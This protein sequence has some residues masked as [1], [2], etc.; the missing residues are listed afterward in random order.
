MKQSIKRV[1]STFLCAILALGVFGCVKSSGG[2]NAVISEPGAKGRYIEQEI[3]IP[4][5]EGSTEQISHWDWSVGERDRSIC[6]YL[7]GKQKTR[8]IVRYFRH[9]IDQAGTVTTTEEQWLNELASD[10]GNE[11]RGSRLMTALFI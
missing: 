6:E 4:L 11:M 9:S 7:F 1:I 2:S 3:K 10:G 5:P 8:T